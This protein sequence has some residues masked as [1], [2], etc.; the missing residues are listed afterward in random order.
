LIIG[1][2]FGKPIAAW[3]AST[4]VL[5]PFG[6]RINGH[7]LGGGSVPFSTHS[8]S[9]TRRRLTSAVAGTGF[10]G[11]VPVPQL[12]PG[13]FAPLREGFWVIAPFPPPCVELGR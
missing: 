2:P 5:S 6:P 10:A 4:S 3:F 9:A 7:L 13:Q 8:R 1:I 12:L 11:N